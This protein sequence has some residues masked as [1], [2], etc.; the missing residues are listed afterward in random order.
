MY[1]SICR[2]P[3]VSLLVPFVGDMA[4]KK[5]KKQEEGQEGH[6]DEAFAEMPTKP[7]TVNLMNDIVFTGSVDDVG[8]QWDW[9]RIPEAVG[10]GTEKDHVMLL[11]NAQQFQEE[12]EQAEVP[13]SSFHYKG[14]GSSK[15]KGLHT[16]GSCALFLMLSLC[17]CRR[18]VKQNHK[19]MALKL[20]RSLIGLTMLTAT[21]TMNCTIFGTDCQY[22]YKYVRLSQGCT[23][24]LAE[25]FG[26]H[27]IAVATWDALGNAGDMSISSALAKASI[28]DLLLFL[29][30]GKTHQ[31]TS[32]LWNDIG[33]FV[34]PRL[35]H[36][37]GG[38]ME[39]YAKALSQYEPKPQPL[40]KSKSGNLR[41]VPFINK[42]IL[43]RR[44]KKSKNHRKSIMVTHDD[45]VGKG[46]DIV[47]HETVMEVSAYME[48]LADAFQNTTHI[49]V[50]W[51]P[52]DYDCN[53]Y[54]GIVW[55]GEAGENGLTEY[56]PNPL[57]INRSRCRLQSSGCKE[58]VD[59][60]GRFCRT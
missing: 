6:T 42:M 8:A 47:N 7:F 49:S 17:A 45:L 34:W 20:L 46:S 28:F 16:M 33:A 57:N 2:C 10:F 54:V 58:K 48:Q 38:A 52:S 37:C 22:H 5:K 36:M 60:G 44:V 35:V 26:F 19:L 29:L 14:Q 25:L 43:L 9:A 30:Y 13:W 4:P 39:E 31:S 50:H 24:D 51:D 21:F 32:S 40:M 27:S 56:R 53:T 15:D 23:E 18:A 1:N 3:F 41:R 59:Q 11:R 55:S 12:C